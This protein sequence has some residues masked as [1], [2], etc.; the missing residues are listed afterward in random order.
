[1]K[2][3]KVLL[4]II[5]TLVWII[6]IESYSL[7]TIASGIFIGG[8]C[9]FFSSRFLPLNKIK[10]VNFG[11]LAS[12]PFYLV[13]QVFVSAIYVTKIIFKGAK[14]DIVN[15]KTKVKN[16]S[17]RVM[18]ADSVTLTPGSVM[19]ELE[20]EK[21]IVLWLRERGSPEIETLDERVVAENI[22][23]K[24]ERKLI[25]AQEEVGA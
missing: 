5:L 10:G 15:I 14:I 21:M 11:K 4:V 3:G 1:M 23:G 2:R 17:I 13:G 20:G 18:L 22:M 8:G 16:D 19:L 6:L 24:L 9:V 7:L 25:L 12:Y